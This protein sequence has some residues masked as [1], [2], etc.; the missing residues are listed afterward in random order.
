MILWETKSIENKR[1]IALSEPLNEIGRMLG[2]WNG[3][4][5][6]ENS[7]ETAQKRTGEK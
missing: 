7:P 2:G 3:K 4:L 1:Y 5:T 6:K